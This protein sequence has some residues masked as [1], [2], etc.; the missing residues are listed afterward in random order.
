[1]TQQDMRQVLAMFV[2]KQGRDVP[3]WKNN[4]PGLDFIKAAVGRRKLEDFFNNIKDTLGNA[5]QEHVCN[6]DITDDPGAKIVL[7]SR[8]TKRVERVQEHSRTSVSVMVCGTAKDVL[9]PPMVVYKAQ[10]LYEY[11]SRHRL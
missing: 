3:E 5:L 4:E 9:L 2:T 11:W 7:V 1:M 10:H 6:Y 8:G